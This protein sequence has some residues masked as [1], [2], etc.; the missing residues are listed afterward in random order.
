MRTSLAFKSS[1]GFCAH[2][3]AAAQ[4]ICKSPRVRSGADCQRNHW[5]VPSTSRR[6]QAA[7]MTAAAEPGVPLARRVKRSA[8]PS[9]SSA[10]WPGNTSMAS[11]SAPHWDKPAC[12]A[13]TSSARCCRRDWV[14][15]MLSRPRQLKTAIKARMLIATRSSIKVKPPLRLGGVLRRDS[16]RRRPARGLALAIKIAPPRW[17]PSGWANRH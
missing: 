2:C 13:S 11:R 5:P 9:Q 17:T 1:P 16:P 6:D 4:A 14:W 10:D 15:V 8:R 7:T 3:A 12:S